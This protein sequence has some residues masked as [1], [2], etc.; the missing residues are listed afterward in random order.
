MPWVRRDLLH[1]DDSWRDL[2]ACRGRTDLFFPPEIQY[3]TVD[4]R[5][6]HMLHVNEAKAICSTC[7]VQDEC[8]DFAL[9]NNIKHGIW[10]GFSMSSSARS[11]RKKTGLRVVDTPDPSLAACRPVAKYDGPTTENKA[12][13][14]STPTS[15]NKVYPRYPGDCP[16]F[17]YDDLEG[18][19]PIEDPYEAYGRRD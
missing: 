14:I 17:D 11:R 18:A 5:R 7:P 16:G 6:L 12:V 9:T 2:A 13:M 10:G 4:Q 15:G 8:L 3:R 1:D 19:E